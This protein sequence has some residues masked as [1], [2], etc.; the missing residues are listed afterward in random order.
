MTEDEAVE[1]FRARADALGA[2]VDANGAVAAICARLDRLPLALELAAARMTLFT[3][4]QLLERLGTQLDLLKGGRDADARQRTLRATIEWSHDLLDEEEQRLFRQLSIFA[5]GCTYEAAEGVCAA[6]PDTLQSLIDKSLLRRREGDFGP[7]YWMLETI[8]EYAAERLGEAGEEAAVAKGHATWM[9]NLAEELVGMWP[10]GRVDDSVGGFAEELDNV[11]RALAWT[12]ATDELDLALRLGPAC[13]RF[14]LERG[15]YRDAVSWLEQSVPVSVGA[16]PVGLNALRAQGVIAFAVIGDSELAGRRWTEAAE[17]ARRLGKEEEL[18]LIEGGLASVV[19]EQGDLER[20]MHL[21]Q[22]R[23]AQA[24]MRGDRL[25]EAMYLHWIGE[26]FGELERF[27]EAER[28]LLEADA[29]YRELGNEW[30]RWNNVHSLADVALDRHD[31]ASAA[32]LYGETLESARATARSTPRHEAYCL[33][34]LAS[35]LAEI[36]QDVVAARV[37]GAVCAAEETLGFRLLPRE[38]RRYERHVA[39]LESTDGWVAGRELTLEE[40]AMLVASALAAAG[41]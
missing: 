16:T 41:P 37:W 36:E 27:G 31:F 21:R 6:T 9:C 14:W 29:I 1:L 33:A 24:R 32:T 2:E 18:E 26:I 13:L 28:S 35:V 3:P 25:R 38:R 40:A 7:R 19:W 30:E 20:A 17:L 5:N 12:W 8:R 23:L 39:R 10:V 11:R 4:A 34:G 22:E 15:H